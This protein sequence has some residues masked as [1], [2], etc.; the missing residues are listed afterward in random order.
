MKSKILALAACLVVLCFVVACNSA[1]QQVITNQVQVT[2]TDT[3]IRQTGAADIE[4][5][6]YY[7]G[8][9]VEVP[10]LIKNDSEKTID[11]VIRTLFDVNPVAYPKAKGYVAVP[12]YYVDWVSI[13]RIGSI[14]PGDAKSYTVALAIPSNAKEKIPAQWAFKI[15]VSGNNGGFFQTGTQSWWRINMR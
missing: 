9:R 11:P 1:P 4:V 14:E 10:Y 7:K 2:I 5:S 13:P 15:E 6:N 8:A 12:N 3:G